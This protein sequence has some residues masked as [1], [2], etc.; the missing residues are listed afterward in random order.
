ML[1]LGELLI[2]HSSH[3]LVNLAYLGPVLAFLVWL[4]F[5]TLKERRQETNGGEENVGQRPKPKDHQSKDKPRP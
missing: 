1:E 3:W 2:A 4:G 5:T